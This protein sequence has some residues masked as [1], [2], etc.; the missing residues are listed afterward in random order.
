MLGQVIDPNT[1]AESNLWKGFA[2][3]SITKNG[4]VNPPSKVDLP[5]G[6]LCHNSLVNLP[7]TEVPKEFFM[8]VEK[9]GYI[10]RKLTD[11]YNIVYPIRL[12]SMRAQ[13]GK[14]T[15]TCSV[16][17]GWANVN[18]LRAFIANG[19]QSIDEQGDRLS[20][21]LS[22]KGVIYYRRQREN[23]R[24]ILSVLKNLGTTERMRSELEKDGIPFQY[25]KPKELISYLV[26]IGGVE[27]D[28][29]MD[30]FAGSGTTAQAV[31]ELN[32]EV[33]GNRKFILVQMPEATPADSEARKAGYGTI[34]DICNERVRRVIKKL[35]PEAKGKNLDLGFKLFKLGPT[36]FAKWTGFS[37]DN[38]TDYE[39]ELALF[40]SAVKEDAKEETLLSEV[41]LREGFPLTS[42]VATLEYDGNSIHKVESDVCEHRLFVCLE[43]K[44]DKRLT[45]TTF[46]KTGIGGE[47]VFI[48]LDE[49]L[50]DEGKNRISE[51][52]SLKVI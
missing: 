13:N 52:C 47:D 26:R 1:R 3:N 45:M 44:L 10:T 20:F 40:S 37:G 2:E 41:I 4:P 29:V 6:F 39:K 46:R 9:Q 17:S 30:F 49:A 21:Y 32:K 18:K 36:S 15:S 27:H 11:Q 43:R 33:G 12:N 24:N 35:K 38:L 22:E 23:A 50:N 31:L 25:P 34:A 5:V 51:L 28:T 42:K 14:L 48:C 7:A 16:Y 19:C 8:A